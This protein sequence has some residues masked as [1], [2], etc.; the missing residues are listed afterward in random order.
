MNSSLKASN[1][2]AVV[3]LLSLAAFWP[4]QSQ[5]LETK[6]KTFIPKASIE[7]VEE[8]E[9]KEP[10]TDGWHKSLK[11]A[12]NFNMSQARNIVGVA[13]GTTLALGLNIDGGLIFRRGLHQW[14]NTL[15]ILQTQ[16]KVPHLKPF[17]KA[18]DRLDLES[19]YMYEIPSIEWLGFFGG[20]RV[21]TPLFSG[22]L[23]PEN[24]TNLQLTDNDENITSDIAY[25]QKYY[26]LTKPFSPMLFRQFVG[27]IFMPLKKS[28]MKLDVRVGPGAMQGW[29]WSGWVVDDDA[30]TEDILEIRQLEDFVQIG[31]EV[32]L[33]AV[34]VIVKDT[35]SYTLRAGAMYPFYTSRDTDLKGIDLMNVEF[36]FDLAITLSKWAALNYSLSAMR[37]PMLVDKWQVSN[38]LMFS[39]TANLG[40]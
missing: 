40:T 18:S 25:G 31:S 30:D 20:L 3:M 12:L 21:T 7:K 5:A 37:V 17:I 8:K 28:W 11:A 23:V 26:R 34:G 2:L 4:T 29:T 35:L 22:N 32:Q 10:P 19:F 24:D 27:A 9:K 14:R 36:A 39:L 33:Q 6:D 16:T 15:I 13:D 1:R 38:S